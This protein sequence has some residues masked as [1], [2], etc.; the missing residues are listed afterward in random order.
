MYTLDANIFVRDLDT[1]EPHHAECHALLNELQRQGIQIVVPLLVLAEVAGTL[2][3]MRR[4]PMA[5]RL[6]I[7]LLRSIGN[8]FF[9]P[10]DESLAQDAAELAADYALRGA[11]AIY[12]AVARRHNCVLVSLDREQRERSTAIVTTYTPAEALANL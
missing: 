5:G 1:R 4:D 6:A 10:M 9:V 11:D 12:V 3:R 7:D 8:L 2:S